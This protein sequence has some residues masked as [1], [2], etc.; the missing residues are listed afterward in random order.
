MIN[1][2][3]FLYMKINLINNIYIP[4][5]ITVGDICMHWWNWTYVLIIHHL[6][7]QKFMGEV[8]RPTTNGPSS[9]NITARIHTNASIIHRYPF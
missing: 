9:T 5:I 2:L 8:A 6:I 1:L 7:C 3:F 4:Y